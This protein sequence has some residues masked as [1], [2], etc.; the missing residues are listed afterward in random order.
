MSLPNYDFD[1]FVWCKFILSGETKHINFNLWITTCKG[2][3]LV[4]HSCTWIQDQYSHL[5]K[6]SCPSNFVHSFIMKKSFLFPLFSVWIALCFKSG[7]DVYL[8]LK[9]K[10]EI[11]SRLTNWE[12]CIFASKIDVKYVTWDVKL[13]CNLGVFLCKTRLI[14]VVEDKQTP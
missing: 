4:K 2:I 13:V 10:R 8:T 6:G 12:S 14:W 3:I 9:Q 5:G 11:Y 1:M 7:F